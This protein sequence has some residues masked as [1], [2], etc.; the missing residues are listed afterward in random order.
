M[1]TRVLLADD[2]TIVRQG[3]KA[4]LARE[5]IDVVAEAAT[6]REA[7]QL[8][9]A[10]HADVAVLDLGMPGLNGIDAGREIMQTCPETRIL[11]LTQ[12][13][14]EPYVTS[15]M[16][17]GIHG[18]ILKSQAASDLV[19]AIREVQRGRNYLS[20]ALS[21]VLVEALREQA[22]FRQDPL[23]L[24]EREVLQLVAEGQSSKEIARTLGISAKTAESHRS[25]IMA[26]LGLH[27]TASLVRYAIRHHLVAP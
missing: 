23:T 25:R 27:E 21:Q 19:H 17:A 2:H 16:R 9:L 11:L 4:L 10:H 6:G 5:G 13:A 12:H 24:R 8:A 14:E 26:K 1:S 15:A 7:L 22:G 20:A 18:Y 3:L